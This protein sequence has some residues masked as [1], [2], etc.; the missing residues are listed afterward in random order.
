MG[1]VRNKFLPLLAWL[2]MC[3][4]GVQ[5]SAGAPTDLTTALAGL[6]ER[7]QAYYDRISSIICTETVTQ[8]TLTTGLQPTGR[9]RV[10][11]YELRVTL[12]QRDKNESEF[13]VGRT[14]QLVNGRRARKHEEPGCTDPK[15]GTPEPLGFLLAKNQHRSRFSWPGR[16]SGGPPGTLALDFAQS[17]PDRVTVAWNGNCFQAAGGGIEGRIW[18]D[19]QTFDVLQL[20]TRLPRPFLVPVPHAVGPAPTSIRVERSEML[21]HFARVAFQQPDEVVLLPESIEV[22]SL[23]RGA[24]SL[25]TTQTLSDFR[26]FLTDAVVRPV[27]R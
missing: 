4:H 15:T 10:T 14:L 2:A 7:V 18:F 12:E 11:V 6:A 24:P 21:V 17:P 25:K 5:V 20:Q 3:G 8:R 23:L 27:S 9:P 13:R 22:V 26:R 19:P 16:I 1:R